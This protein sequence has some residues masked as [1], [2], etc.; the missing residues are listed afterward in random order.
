ME[1]KCVFRKRKV[2]L[3]EELHK[4]HENSHYNVYVYNFL[5]SLSMDQTHLTSSNV[6]V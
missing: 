3:C 5:A 6:T 4:K 1:M 2:N